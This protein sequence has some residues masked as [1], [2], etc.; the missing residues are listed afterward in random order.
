MK[1]YLILTLLLLTLNLAAH[2]KSTMVIDK[3]C[4]CLNENK[5]EATNFEEFMALLTKCVSPQIKENIQA[6]KAEFAIPETDLITLTAIIG[7]KLGEKM[8]VDCPKFAATITK[9]VSENSEYQGL[10]S[11]DLPPVTSQPMN[12][13]EYGTVI[14]ITADSFPCQFI[15]ETKNGEKIAV[16]LLDE[17]T[18][19]Q[20]YI[21]NPTELN[22]KK[23]LFVY[24]TR[25]LYDPELKN[26]IYTNVLLELNP[27]VE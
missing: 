25:K 12:I 15:I 20:A 22:D 17:I 1:L 3:S 18:L 4:G 8:A 27:V 7:E 5:I 24:E 21:E 9:L 10:I 13:T 23:V 14:L 16:L 11:D 2:N 19:D 26:Y 6:L